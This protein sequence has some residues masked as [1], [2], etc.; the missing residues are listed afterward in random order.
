MVVPIFE[1][2]ISSVHQPLGCHTHVSQDSSFQSTG[3]E[4][5]TNCHTIDSK[6]TMWS[7]AWPRNSE[8][9]PYVS[10]LAGSV[11]GVCP[12]SLYVLCRLGVGM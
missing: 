7:P 12:A 3:K 9:R 1:T 10:Q 5:L 4:V 6:G 8:P 2:G 11:M